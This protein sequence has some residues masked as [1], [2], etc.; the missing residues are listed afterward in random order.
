MGP[1]H[2]LGRPSQQVPVD[3]GKFGIYLRK[4]QLQGQNIDHFSFINEIVRHQHFAKFSLGHFSGL[5]GQTRLQVG[6]FDQAQLHQQAPDPDGSN[7]ISNCLMNLLV[8]DVSEFLQNI[9]NRLRRFEFG[10]HSER[11]L[12]LFGCEDIVQQQHF[13]HFSMIL[14]LRFVQGGLHAVL[15]SVWVYP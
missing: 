11:I 15:I 10:M 12:Q 1:A 3:I 13:Y 4:P 7:V 5:D 8:G 14:R 9:Q 6:G 2:L